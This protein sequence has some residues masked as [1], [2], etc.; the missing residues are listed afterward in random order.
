MPETEQTE[1]RQ[2]IAVYVPPDVER[3]DIY[4]DPGAFAHWWRVATMFGEAEIIPAHL[5]K[6]IPDIM[7][8][9]SLARRL[10][11]EPLLVL[12]SMFVVNGTPGFKASFMVALA[13]AAG[14]DLDYETELLGGTLKWK[15]RT[16]GGEIVAEAENMRVR[17]TMTR[18]DKVKVGIW[19]SL[20]QAISAGW[21]NNEQYVHSTENQLSWRAAAFAIRR[22]DPNLLLGLATVE[23]LRD[24]DQGNADDAP[25]KATRTRARVAI[26]EKLSPSSSP[27]TASGLSDAS[28]SGSVA[29][30]QAPVGDDQERSNQ[31]DAAGQPDDL[32][33]DGDQR[34]ALLD[35]VTAL[36]VAFVDT[37]GDDALN[38]VVELARKA[39]LPLDPDGDPVTD[40]APDAALLRYRDAL[41]S[42]TE[43]GE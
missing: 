14:W 40:G 28:S 32:P 23:E 35:Q 21:A 26:E 29:P 17:V 34:A 4:A 3:G 39:G 38:A 41:L 25:P 15:R 8:G 1:T 43:A 19:V 13:T 42:A 12:Q 33:L 27:V 31:A 10:R 2:Q 22:T 16:K 37:G 20:A 9:L 36:V 6:H 24:G 5:R 11:V 7:I 18:G 30:E